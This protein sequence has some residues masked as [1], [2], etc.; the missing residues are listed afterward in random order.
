MPSAAYRAAIFWHPGLP[1][2]GAATPPETFERVFRAVGVACE[3][4]DAAAVADPARLNRA[5][6]DLLVV[7]TGAS[8]PAAGQ[9]ALLAFLKQGGDLLCTGGYAFDA[10]MEMQDGVWARSSALLAERMQ[11]GRDPAAATIPNGGFEEGLEGWITG[12]P[13]RVATAAE[14]R[15]GKACVTVTSELGSGGAGVTHGLD[16]EPGRTY[17]VGASHRTH[18]V[19]GVGFAFVAVYQY[20]A[21]GALL[22]FRDFSQMRGDTPWKRS[23]YRV[24]IHP[25]ARLVQFRCGLYLASGQAW[26]DDVTCAETP[27]EVR[28]NA[29]YGDPQD[30]LLVQSD[31]LPIYSPDQRFAGVRCVTDP[32]GP[33][34]GTSWR[35]DGAVSG[36]DATAQLRAEARWM[37]LVRAHDRYGRAVGCPGALVSWRKGQFR[38][39]Q[40][41]IFG[42]VDRD[43]FAGPTGGGLLAQVI[44]LLRGGISADWLAGDQPIYNPGETAL[45]SSRITAREPGASVECALTL[46]APAPGGVWRRVAT[47][48]VT[49][50]P[51]TDG[52]AQVSA[53]WTAPTD[54]PDFIRARLVVRAAGRVV[55][56]C[57]TGF[58][59][60]NPEVV[61]RGVR[62]AFSG[63]RFTLTPP[64]GKPRRSML[65]GTDTY[66]NML[67]S[68]NCSPLTWYRD[69]ET[70]RDHGLHM[71]EMLQPCPPGFVFDEKLWRQT[72]ALVQLA[73]RFGL[74][75]M[76]GLLIGQNVAVDDATLQRQAELCR[77]FALRNRAAPG[78]LYYLNGDYQLRISDT[79]DLRRHWNDFLTKRYGGDAALRA[80]WGSRAPAEA[81]GSIPLQEAPP[82]AWFD[83]RARDLAEFKA[84]LVRRWNETLVKAVRSVD[85]AHPILGEYYQRPWD[86]IDLRLSMGGMD[87]ANYGY[88]G[89]PRKDL[90]EMLATLR[91]NDMTLHGQGVAMGEFGVKTHDGWAADREPSDYHAQRTEPEQRRLF[92]WV[93][94]AAFGAGATKVQNWCWSDDPDGM[95]PWGMATTNP[96]RGKP[97][98]K[99]YR[100]LS[101]VSDLVEPAQRRPQAILVMPDA[102]RLGAPDT[103]GRLGPMNALQCLVA[104]GVDFLTANE[105]DLPGLLRLRPKLVV[106]PLAYGLSDGSV[107]AL[108]ALARQGATVYLSGDPSVR[109][110]G[111]RDLERL[112]RL[113]GV[114]ETGRREEAGSLPVVNLAPLPGV[115]TLRAGGRTFGRHKLGAGATLMAEEPWEAL[116]KLDPA[117][118]DYDALSDPRRNPYAT[119]FAGLV[120][121]QSERLVPGSGAWR[122]ISVPRSGGG[123]LATLCPPEDGNGPAQVSAI[124]AGRDV[125]LGGARGWPCLVHMD[126]TGGLRAVSAAGAVAVGK[127]LVVSGSGGPFVAASLD[128]LPLERSRRI[129]LCSVFGGVVSLQGPRVVRARI[130]ERRAGVDATVAPAAVRRSAGG[131][132]VGCPP[133]DWV[134]VER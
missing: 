28:I 113:C 109:P 26:F 49:L 87:C 16:V 112:E 121:T 100:S 59:V 120:R 2:V 64:G 38:G 91:W 31:Q 61:R 134:E 122:L 117:G 133:C 18:G 43:L 53:R 29:H 89:P 37:P 68:P 116:G 62:I 85:R 63:N 23:E 7:S 56:R 78:L 82:E 14:A 22:T 128:G 55:D 125:R 75:Y 97:A 44:A 13:A 115:W 93:V 66:G 130:V 88:F 24:T 8:Y 103:L 70:M 67:W 71:W 45:L 107:A 90:R 46:D 110:D 36:Y 5:R 105:A 72:D 20:G 39:G 52:A 124:V 4:L 51:W 3:R 30:A 80:A 123:T 10:P 74:P 104:A 84:W 27:A 33:L 132:S 17:L 6:F 106:A 77:A 32:D 79:P 54:A 126:G 47:V 76:A 50:G 92:W 131:S 114:R 42:V 69:L 48:P 81:L 129:G 95:F 73:Q 35:L 102:W 12:G 118:N 9:S 65:F 58:C 60:S 101:R 83:L 41:A 57:E 119:L 98:A 11:Q 96:L 127:R 94:H 1:V 19:R 15:T 40:W 86:G 21:D 108:V 111:T 34:V 25:Q 99:L